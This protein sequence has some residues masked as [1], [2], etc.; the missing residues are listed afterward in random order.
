[1]EIF[2]IPENPE[3]SDEIR[4]LETTDP[5]HA[6]V[7]NSILQ[8]LVGNDAFVKSLTEN[9]ILG[10]GNLDGSMHI[11]PGGV[12][13]QVLKRGSSSGS[14]SWGSDSYYGTCSTAAATAEKKVFVNGSFALFSGSTVIVMFENG[15]TAEYP[16]LRINGGAAKRI[17]Y[18]G[19]EITSYIINKGEILELVY[20][21]DHW[22]IVGNF[23]FKKISEDLDDVCIPG[24]YQISGA[25][26]PLP[27]PY[28]YSLIVLRSDEGMNHQIALPDDSPRMFTRYS[29]SLKDWSRWYEIMIEDASFNKSC[30]TLWSGILYDNISDAVFYAPKKYWHNDN[31]TLMIDCVRYGDSGMPAPY[32]KTVLITLTRPHKIYVSEENVVKLNEY[33]ASLYYDR[34]VTKGS[35][36]EQFSTNTGCCNDIIDIFALAE[37]LTTNDYAWVSVH[38]LDSS[39]YVITDIYAVIPQMQEE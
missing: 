5:G 36:Y 23:P 35:A 19:E 3:Y 24:L 26:G 9:H 1:M 11:P 14:A 17:C 10:N 27:K 7:F 30:V 18:M 39:R 37:S 6:D 15:N 21:V 33:S 32:S 20:T 13:G 22:E 29:S 38:K 8:K 16:T 25:N 4:K 28:R 31:L 2:N 12:E 34:G